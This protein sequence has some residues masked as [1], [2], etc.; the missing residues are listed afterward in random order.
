M[1]KAG[2]IL[3]ILFE[4]KDLVATGLPGV[5]LLS[6]TVLNYEVRRVTIN[7]Q[8]VNKIHSLYSTGSLGKRNTTGGQ[9]PLVSIVCV[10][11]HFLEPLEVDDNKEL[12][13][14]ICK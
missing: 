12:E 10:R 5:P 6:H 4:G 7:P 8:M 9:C 13:T 2:F 11:A 3:N 1:I 14:S